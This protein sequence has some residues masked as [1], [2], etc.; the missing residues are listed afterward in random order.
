[1]GFAKAYDEYEDLG[2]EVDPGDLIG[3]DLEENLEGRVAALA[4]LAYLWE[5]RSE[6]PGVDHPDLS[7]AVARAMWNRATWSNKVLGFPGLD[8]D[9]VRESFDLKQT[10]SRALA[11]EVEGSLYGLRDTFLAELRREVTIIRRGALGGANPPKSVRSKANKYVN[12]I[13]GDIHAVEKL[14]ARFE[15]ESTGKIG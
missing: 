11:A 10:R 12:S 6:L 14:I 15:S 13:L 3:Y 4:G 7:K 1:M 2:L 9:E 5:V 8:A